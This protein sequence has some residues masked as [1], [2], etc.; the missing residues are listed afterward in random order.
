M[1]ISIQNLVHQSKVNKLELQPPVDFD[2]IKLIVLSTSVQH[3]YILRFEV[4]VD[5]A[6]IMHALQSQNQ[7]YGDL[8]GRLHAKE[9][10]LIHFI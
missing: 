7:L 4:T 5:V 9:W 8:L 1:T 3:H 6:C 10:K 2:V